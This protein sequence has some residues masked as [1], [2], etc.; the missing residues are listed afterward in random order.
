ME[1]HERLT[2]ERARKTIPNVPAPSFSSILNLENTCK[3]SGRSMEGHGTS[4][5]GHGMSM[6]NLANICE[7]KSNR[8]RHQ[9]SPEATRSHQ[10]PPEAT[11]SHQKS[12]EAIR[13]HRKP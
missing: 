13:S 5:E 8:K 7:E 2:F 12:P 10:K 11:R 3:A 9:K 6:S 4:V 1:G